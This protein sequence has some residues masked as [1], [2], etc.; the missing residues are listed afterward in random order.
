MDYALG[1]GSSGGAAMKD[2]ASTTSGVLSC[3]I[4]GAVSG[5]TAVAVIARG[6]H[7]VMPWQSAGAH[8]T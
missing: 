6:A 5:A 7:G 3:T 1:G 4:A 8:G 2:G